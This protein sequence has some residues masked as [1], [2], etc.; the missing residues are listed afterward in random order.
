MQKQIENLD[1]TVRWT[2]ARKPLKYYIKAFIVLGNVMLVTV[3]VMVATGILI[4]SVVIFQVNNIRQIR[5]R[6]SRRCHRRTHND[7]LIQGIFCEGKLCHFQEPSKCDGKSKMRGNSGKAKSQW[8]THRKNSLAT[9]CSYSKPSSFHSA[10][11]VQLQMH[12]RT[13]WKDILI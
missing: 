1:P 4:V 7:V 2:L 9:S 10:S 13:P 8:S 5:D 6:R 3:I 11:N 12:S